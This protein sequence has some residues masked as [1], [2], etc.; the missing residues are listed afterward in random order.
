MTFKQIALAVFRVGGTAFAVRLW[1][2]QPGRSAWQ[3]LQLTFRCFF[4]LFKKS[5]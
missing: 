2:A 3:Q 1:K 4:N 5:V